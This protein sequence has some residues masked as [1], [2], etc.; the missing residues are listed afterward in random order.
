[1]PA[2]T[3][4]PSTVTAGGVVSVAGID[5]PAGTT[6]P[7][8]AYASLV[9][10]TGSILASGASETKTS[11][12]WKVKVTVPANT[13]TGSYNIDSTCDMYLSSFSYPAVALTV[14]SGP[15]STWGPQTTVN[16]AL[17]DGTL[18][19][20]S[21]LSSSSCTAVGSHLNS[22]GQVVALAEVWNGAS[23]AIQPLSNPAG[24]AD[25]EL[26]G[27][28]CTSSVICTAVGS[29][30]TSMGQALALVEVWNGTGWAVQPVPN[31]TGATG[32]Y[33]SEVSCAS[34]AACSAVGYYYTSAGQSLTLAEAWNGTK[35]KLQ[36]SAN[37][38]GAT[39]TYL[40]GVS[41]LT[42]S[43]CTAAGYYFNGSGGPFAL[44]EVW[45]GNTWA[46]QSVPNPDGATG[47]YLVGVSCTSGSACSAVGYYF[48][49]SGQ[50]V[51]LAE[52]WNGTK[53]K[54]R[55]TPNPAGAVSSELAGVSCTSGSSCSAVGYYSNN[56][57][58]EFALAE[59]WNGTTWAT[60]TVPDPA[61]A[62]DV[63]LSGVACTSDCIAV[64]YYFSS[65]QTLAVADLWNG[66]TWSTQTVPDPTGATA[67]DLPAV[68]C[69]S[70]AACTAVGS[71]FDSSG[72]SLPFAEVWGG[73]TWATQAVPSPPGAIYS[74]LSG[75]SCTTS[76]A[77]T[78]VG[79]YYNS[80]DETLPLAEEWN[81][82]AWAIQPVPSPAG[83]V[84]SQLSGLSCI[85]IAACTAVGYYD[86]SSDEAVPLVEVWNG[87]K[88]KLQPTANPT[89]G[90][91]IQLSGVS[92]TSGSACTAVGY[93]NNSSGLEVTLVEVR[94]GTTWS[95]KS[96]PNP[97][98]A[99]SSELS[100]VSCTS[101]SAC[102]A[103]GSY[104][105]NSPY[106]MTLAEVWNGT[107]WS[108]KTT[109]DGS[110]DDSGLTGVSCLS[111]SACTAV[112]Y[113][114]NYGDYP[115][116]VEVWNGVNWSLQST[117]DQPGIENGLSGVSCVSPTACV[118]A[119]DQTPSF[120]D[121]SF[122]GP[123]VTFVEAEGGA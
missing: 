5:C 21:C 82:T 26:T 45:N 15:T 71:Y 12:S 108:V 17:P 39:F 90:N 43:A 25:S 65:S 4:T 14:N 120:S 89:G 22:S 119:G 27:V 123:H 98:G 29:Y 56:S 41:C 113:T 116:L 49:S 34:S 55:P 97:V 57:G 52:G 109:L 23:W 64:G 67:S 99:D 53:W 81:G 38:T 40:S 104:R 48:N 91:N 110:G 114:E 87:T 107:T 122:Y 31:P 19:A 59:A 101:G 61:G 106:G 96:A 2:P 8:T 7:V 76:A 78:A 18:D 13:A 77:C 93:Y 28:A 121:G 68:S 75:V 30:D 102:T 11:G 86:N 60:Q 105:K 112:G 20:V 72:G 85:S 46:V 3:V 1:M 6:G 47:S 111:A 9:D 73:T 51:T 37:P 70:S 80:S 66:S 118:A 117:P 32:T 94:T 44:V 95:I 62:N 36:P 16:P 63:A 88:W 92:C 24:V 33:L 69:T 50:I 42:A 10:S 83:A 35:W 54:M 79:S 84:Y 58:Q 74:Q 100:S 115:P 103:V